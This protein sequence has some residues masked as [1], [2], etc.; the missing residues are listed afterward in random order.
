M[1]TKEK[2]VVLQTRADLT[3]VGDVTIELSKISKSF[4]GAYT[5]KGS[6]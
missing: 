5:I 6:K 1:D 2:S 3:M 4:N